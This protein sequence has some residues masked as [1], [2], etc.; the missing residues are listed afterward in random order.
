MCSLIHDVNIFVGKSCSIREMKLGLTRFWEKPREFLWV[1]SN[2]A[3]SNYKCTRNSDSVLVHISQWT[4]LGGQQS[5]LLVSDFSDEKYP[6]GA[7][8]QA[9]KIALHWYEQLLPH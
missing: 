8:R 5:D 4:Y 9:A 1:T 2:S 3:F 7:K 6:S